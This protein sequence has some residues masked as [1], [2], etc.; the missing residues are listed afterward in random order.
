MHFGEQREASVVYLWG[1]NLIEDSCGEIASQCAEKCSRQLHV[2]GLNAEEIIEVASL[3]FK[4][5]LLLWL[6]AE[7][8]KQFSA[9]FCPIINVSI[10]ET[11]DRLPATGPSE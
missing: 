1:Y 3:L 9:D 5:F 7:L 2:C 6:S 4:N 10:R 11:I 8:L